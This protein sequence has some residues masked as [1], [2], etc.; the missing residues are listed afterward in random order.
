MKFLLRL[1]VTIVLLVLLYTLYLHSEGRRF[2]AKS[3]LLKA[4]R[5]ASGAWRE[6]TSTVSFACSSLQADLPDD[7]NAT[8]PGPD[9]RSENDATR[10]WERTGPPFAELTSRLNRAIERLNR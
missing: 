5:V 7:S 2:D 6:T 1:L 8:E 9:D 10:E 4:Q 3:E